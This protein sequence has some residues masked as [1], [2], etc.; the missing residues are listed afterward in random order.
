MTDQHTLPVVP[1]HCLEAAQPQEQWLIEQL[2]GNRSVGILGGEPKC[3]KSFFT[4]HMAVAVA[5]GT[6]CLHRFPVTRP[7]RVLLFPAEDA[8]HI[9]RARLDAICQDSSLDLASLD[10]QVIT[11]STVRL[12]LE[13][14]RRAL[15]STVAS[16]QPALLILDPFVR[17]HCQDEN[18]SQQVAPLLAFLRHIQREYHLAVLVVHHARKG[19]NNTRAGQA[20]R[21]SSEFHAWGDDLLYLR[22]HGPL[23]TLS[24]EHRAASAIPDISLRLLDRGLGAIL[25]IQDQHPENETDSPVSSSQRVEAILAQAA[26]PLPL[27][28]LREACRMRTATLCDTL[29]ALTANG[30]ISKTRDGYCLTPPG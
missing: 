15:V 28:S 18:A 10:I 29:T 8:Q 4:L 16:L 25:Q 20:L 2:F 9:V 23:I 6:P 26:G 14:D 12:D 27:R 3:A 1:A 5:S 30:R 17:L 19:A 21:G 22:R 7:G 11:A 24:V 13:R